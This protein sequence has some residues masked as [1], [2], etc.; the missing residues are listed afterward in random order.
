MRIRQGGLLHY[1]Y[2]MIMI[3]SDFKEK[4]NCFMIIE[5]K[6]VLVVPTPE[7]VGDPGQEGFCAL[8]KSF[9]CPLL[10]P[11]LQD[12]PTFQGTSSLSHLK[13]C[14]LS[15][16]SPKGGWLGSKVGEDEV[17]EQLFL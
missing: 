14:Y 13:L 17:K 11:E 8:F 6:I 2:N 15:H 10:L 9:T 1:K 4:I 7:T 3:Y 5:S 16:Y 12:F